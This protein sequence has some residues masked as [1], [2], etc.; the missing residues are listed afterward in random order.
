MRVSIDKS[1]DKLIEMQ[2]HAAE[3]TLLKNALDAGYKD[4]EERV[5]TYE[6]FCVLFAAVNPKPA[7]KITLDG[8]V[9][10]LQ[11]KGIITK[12]DVDPSK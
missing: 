11:K 3:G 10:V 4:V 12:D 6:E 1:T 2:S 8:L 9:A 7:P 5:V